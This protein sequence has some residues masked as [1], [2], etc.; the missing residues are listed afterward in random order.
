M[1]V[2]RPLAALALGTAVAGSAYALDLVEVWRAGAQH[3]AQF[4]AARASREAGQARREQAEALW[5]PNV[6]LEGGAAY[7]THETATRG[8][9]F[10]APGFGESSGVGF[11]T[12][13]T[14]T[15]TRV[16]LALRQPL[17]DRERDVQG[18]QL[19]IAAEA[20]ELEWRDAQQALMLRSAERY[21]AAALAAEQLRLLARQQE[22]VDRAHV[23]AQDRFRAGDRPILDAHDAAARAA[24]LKAERVAAQTELEIKRE[25]LADFT[26]TMIGATSLPLPDAAPRSGD[27]GDLQSWLSAAERDNPMLQLA[28]TQLDTAEQ[29]ARKTDVALSPSVHLLASVGRER[30]SGSG[31]YSSA[32]NRMNEHAV[33]V[34][35]AV[36]LYTGGLR[37]A[38]QTEARA[39]V[40]KARNDVERARRQIALETRLAWLD[41]SVGASRIEALEAAAQASRS[42]LDATRTGLQAG[43][44][45]TLD[46]LDAENDT[47]AAELALQQARVRLLTH[48]LRLL[49]LA[50]QLDEARLQQANATLRRL[51]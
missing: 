42:R 33:G 40:D 7:S 26:G 35:V 4:A 43:D 10:S 6:A 41:L 28:R 14:G 22:A 37:S 24:G 11:D 23:E 5:R 9:R 21:F 20:A 13:V 32:S 3:D 50:G 51:H 36:P 44:R 2:A 17:V 15:G 1:R 38:R 46:L 45:T 29:E 25:A 27:L 30:L 47:A 31:D 16:A 49:A 12:S 48:R 39:L 8:A 19:E 34:Q 18:R